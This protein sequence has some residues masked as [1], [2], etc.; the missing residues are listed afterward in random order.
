MELS[1]HRVIGRFAG[2]NGGPLI[3]L[4]AGI[5][6]NEPAGIYAIRRF[7]DFLHQQSSQN[8]AFSWQGSIVGLCGNLSALRLNVRYVG[9]DLNRGWHRTL[10]DYIA[11]AES[12][13]DLSVEEAERYQL[14]AA[15]LEE[16]RLSAASSLIILDL[17]TTSAGGAVFAVPGPD[18]LDFT[19]GLQ[20]PVIKGLLDNLKGTFLEFVCSADWGIPAQAAAFEGGQHDDPSSVDNCVQAIL[21]CCRFAGVS[22]AI[23][24]KDSEDAYVAI[25][26]PLEKMLEVRYRYH[27]DDAAEWQMHPGFVNFSVVVSG[28]KLATYRGEEVICPMDGY[29]L[30]PLYQRQGHDGFFIVGGLASGIHL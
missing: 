27:V 19:M 12:P 18:S 1:Q 24:V 13:Q 11:V 25:C 28:E 9:T 29:L 5:H 17:H 14:A 2:G 16:V 30:M 20:A 3:L 23:G 21:H 15:I 6:G 4:T 22:H 7:F 26:Q 8:P 10:A